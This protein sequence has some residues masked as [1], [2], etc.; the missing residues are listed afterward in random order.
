MMTITKLDKSP[1][2]L[3]YMLTCLLNFPFHFIVGIYI[4]LQIVLNHNSYIER[5]LC[6][7]V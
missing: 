7:M 5:R 1:F 4:S 3:Q 6:L 2:D